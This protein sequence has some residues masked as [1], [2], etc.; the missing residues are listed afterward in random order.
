MHG[1]KAINVRR[2][3]ACLL[4][5][6]AGTF[7]FRELLSDRRTCLAESLIFVR[8]FNNA[9]LK[10]AFEREVKESSP[11]IARVGFLVSTFQ[12]TTLKGTTVQTNGVIRVVTEGATEADAE[13]SANRAARAVG[14]LLER[15][16]S[17]HSAPIGPAQSVS[18][19]ALRRPFGLRLGNATPESFPATGRV[20]FP[21]PALSLDPG[22]GWVRSYIVDRE[23]EYDMTLIGEGKFKGGFIIAFQLSQQVTNIQ[24]GIEDRRHG[25]EGRQGFISSSWKEEPFA[26]ESGLHGAHICYMRQYPAPFQG[27]QVLMTQTTH[28]Y[29]V[30]NAQ[31]RCVAISYT[32][33]V[34]NHELPRGTSPEGG[35][36]EVQEVIRR[37]LRTE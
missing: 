21:K 3:T 35:P 12:E 19:A 27:G 36:Q 34:S 5:A 2:W 25:A 20:L 29:F 33:G 26:T 15:Q 10:R 37:T 1:I 31:S 28:E 14:A 18:R 7:V 4:L 17:I 32:R 8:P 9:L 13:R 23:S 30:T 11:G 16:Y 6:V 24:S 22:E